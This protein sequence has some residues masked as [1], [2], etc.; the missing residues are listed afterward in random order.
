[1]KD[2]RF[3]GLLVMV[4]TIGVALVCVSPASAGYSYDEQVDGDLP[5]PNSAFLIPFGTPNPN[6]IAFTLDVSSDGWILQVDA[7]ETLRAFTLTSFDPDSPYYSATFHMYDGATQQDP[8][9]GVAYAPFDHTF[10]GLDFMDHFGIP[11]LGP[12]FYLFDFWHNNAEYPTVQ[13]DID[14]TGMSPVEPGTWASI[15]NLYR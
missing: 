12:G 5:H 13:F 9:L 3:S 7:G 2:S 1:M 4:A 11:P 8:V 10:T 6:T 14:M 15:K